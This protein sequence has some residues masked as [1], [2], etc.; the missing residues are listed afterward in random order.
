MVKSQQGN[1]KAADKVLN[2]QKVDKKSKR[3]DKSTKEDTI[4]L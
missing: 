4:K 1:P 3:K 2:L